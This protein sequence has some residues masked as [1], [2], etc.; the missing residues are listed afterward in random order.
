MNNGI[1]TSCN[2]RV[3]TSVGLTLGKF[4]PL[5][6][7][8]QFMIE[9]ALR[10]MEHVIVVIYDCPDT[11]DVPLPVRAGWIRKLYP[12]IEVI[13]A[14]DGPQQMGDTPEIKRLQEQYILGLLAGRTVTHFYSSEFYGEHMSTALGAVD[15]RVDEERTMYPISG[16]AVRQAPYACKAYLDPCVYRD[17]VTKVVFLGAPSTG[18]TTISAHMA[19]EY[20]SI[21][22]PEYGRE[23]WEN[24][25][26]ER[27]LTLEQLVEI[28]EG[29][30]EREEAL[31][32]EARDFLWVDTNA[33]TTYMF[34]RYYHGKALPRLEELAS[35]AAA[36][37]DLVFVCEDDI[38]YDDTWDRSGDVQ[39]HVFQKQIKT[40]LILRNISYIPLKG[41]LEQ[42]VSTVKKTLAAYRRYANL[43][44]WIGN[45][46]GV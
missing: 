8:H 23:Y 29:H 9:T 41:T 30:L 40:D 16:T 12:S 14:W 5:H 44:E 15:R 17:L 2:Q 10:E 18:K 28:A 21:W 13:E 11:I 19:K 39:R 33:I 26:I 20:G 27:R 43:A 6:K 38:P 46:C 45:G 34:S 37:Y 31:V 3:I 42:R 4:A 36:R 1:G 7:G 32:Q 25:Q 24:N 22:M 35:Q